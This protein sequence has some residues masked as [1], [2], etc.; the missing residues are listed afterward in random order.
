MASR[1]AQGL[2]RVICLVLLCGCDSASAGTP[3]RSGDPAP[4]L[5]AATGAGGTVVVWASRP[6]DYLSCQSPAFALRRI[7]QR[8]G[9]QVRLVAVSVD[10]RSSDLAADFFRSE[11]LNPTLLRMETREWRRLTGETRLPSLYVSRNGRIVQIWS[12]VARVQAAGTGALPAL[13]LTVD[14]L[15]RAAGGKRSTSR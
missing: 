1:A 6:E 5:E 13:A 9:D 3:M 11:R 4:P 12:S 2:T 10:D 8:F 7:R 14:S 15:F